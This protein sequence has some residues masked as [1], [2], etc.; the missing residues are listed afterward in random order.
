V[1]PA[2]YWPARIRWYPRE[3]TVLGGQRLGQI[4]EVDGR[5]ARDPLDSAHVTL[6][7]RRRIGSAEVQRDGAHVLRSA[8]AVAVVQAERR[9]QHRTRDGVRR[10][11][12]RVVEQAPDALPVAFVLPHPVLGFHDREVRR[13]ES[14]RGAVL[15]RA[16]RI[17]VGAPLV[18]RRDAE[19]HGRDRK[20]GTRGHRTPRAPQEPLH[21]ADT[22]RD[23]GPVIEEGAQV[24]LERGG[25][26]VTLLGVPTHP[27][28]ED[29]LEVA[30]QTWAQGLCRARVAG[31]DGGQHLGRCALVGH[32]QR[33]EV[34]ERRR[35]AVHVLC[36]ARPAAGGE[37][38]RRHVR[39]RAHRDPLAG[40]RRVAFQE[41]DAEVQEDGLARASQEDVGRLDV[42]VQDPR[43]VQRV[44][45][46]RE[47]G[48]PAHGAAQV[49]RVGGHVEA[50]DGP[51]PPR[52]VVG[53]AT[54]HSA[55]LLEEV[56]ERDPLDELHD[57]ERLTLGQRAAVVHR[58]DG[59]VARRGHRRG[60]ALEAR[61]VLVRVAEA[62]PQDLDRDRPPELTVQGAVHHP[63]RAGPEALLE[64]VP[65]GEGRTSARVPR[66]ATAERAVDTR[67][68]LRQGAH[69]VDELG[70]VGRR[71]L[72]PIVTAF[73]AQGEGHCD[74]LLQEGVVEVGAVGSH[75]TF[76]EGVGRRRRRRHGWRSRIASRA[77]RA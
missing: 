54:A 24:G 56:G 63:H 5:R 70:M 44:E 45:P 18:E 19:Q 30:R 77:L 15:A 36:G 69:L 47:L 41:R 42:A 58:D 6:G 8:G 37:H 50:E 46:A 34:V 28:V 25:R 40:Q 60:L 31:R 48:D 57:E 20:H 71:G 2:A 51:H 21:G 17:L 39:R 3:V 53:R 27:L 61:S 55:R 52:V 9:A 16:D 4:D 64:H 49:T 74:E 22:A 32:V 13:E 43:G 72:E 23:D 35:E 14:L 62:E 73:V 65:P 11:L 7:Q 33:E 1:R 75:G 76:G 68:G 29:R 66:H 26:R 38:L 12:D 10:I 67:R 59:S